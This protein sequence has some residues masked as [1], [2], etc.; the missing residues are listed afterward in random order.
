MC[1]STPEV[2]LLKGG[3]RAL[4]F[5]VISRSIKL[6]LFG[7]ATAK[8]CCSSVRIEKR[9]DAAKRGSALSLTHQD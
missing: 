1:G 2:G 3:L 7:I 6:T 8:C 5:A 9:G 4:P